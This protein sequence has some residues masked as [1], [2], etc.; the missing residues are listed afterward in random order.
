MADTRPAPI[1]TLTYYI[2]TKQL[3]CYTSGIVVGLCLLVI[4]LLIATQFSSKEYFSSTVF[5][6][7]TSLASVTLI[8]SL[9]V[10]I[11]EIFNV[12]S[13]VADVLKF[14]E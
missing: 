9:G 6:L 5:W 7:S 1:D 2:R 13:E 10:T 8:I 4:A 3:Y 11:R 14:I 12:N